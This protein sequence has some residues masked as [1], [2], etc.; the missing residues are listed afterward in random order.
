MR[1]IYISVLSTVVGII[2]TLIC[3][4]WWLLLKDRLRDRTLAKFWRLK[5]KKLYIVRPS[6]CSLS[7][8]G[9]VKNMARVED[10]LAIDT[11]TRMLNRRHIKYEVVDHSEPIRDDGDIVLICSPKG[12]D[13]SEEKMY[14]LHF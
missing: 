1:D 14:K 11:L 12:N 8:E 5:N 3:S 6:Y 13:K 2:A 9:A 7:D 10:I 4:W